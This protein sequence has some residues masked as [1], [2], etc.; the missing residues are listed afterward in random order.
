MSEDLKCREARLGLGK[1]VLVLV[2]LDR[3][4]LDQ[5]GVSE[6]GASLPKAVTRRP[7]GTATVEIP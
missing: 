5:D 1:D 4:E 3:S 6:A 2:L 7:Y